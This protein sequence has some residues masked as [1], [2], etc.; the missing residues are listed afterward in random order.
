MPKE[1]LVN[2]NDR[3]DTNGNLVAKHL[4][5]WNTTLVAESIDTTFF[6]CP[7]GMRLKVEGGK[8]SWKT[9]ESG[10]T[11]TVILRRCQGVEAAA[12]GDAIATAVNA[13]GVA[14]TV[15]SL[16]ITTTNNVHI[17]DPGDRL[18]WDFTDD[19]PGELANVYSTLVLSQVA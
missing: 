4:I 17:L 10:G 1:Y 6:I 15:A 7:D 12:S 16:T 19:T 3:T 5:A 14:E 8:I 9:P 2:G 13:V 18:A 11:V